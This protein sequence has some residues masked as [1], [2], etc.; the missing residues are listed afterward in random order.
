MALLLSFAVREEN[1]NNYNLKSGHSL[2]PNKEVNYRSVS[3]HCKGFEWLFCGNILRSK[4]TK[5]LI[6]FCRLPQRY[7]ST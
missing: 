2:W 3:L 7:V 5:N 4:P 6:K 1:L